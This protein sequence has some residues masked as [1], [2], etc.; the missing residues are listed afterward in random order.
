MLATL[1]SKQRAT[2]SRSKQRKKAQN[3][4]IR[5]QIEILKITLHKLFLLHTLC[6][7]LL[8]Y[9]YLLKTTQKKKRREINFKTFQQKISIYNFLSN[10]TFGLFFP[11]TSYKLTIGKNVLFFCLFINPHKKIQNKFTCRSKDYYA[12]SIRIYRQSQ[13]HY[14]GR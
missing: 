13:L 14:S 9:K 7:S 2:S 10:R 11:Q 5:Q 3:E 8:G 4:E 1:L 12:N 6:Y